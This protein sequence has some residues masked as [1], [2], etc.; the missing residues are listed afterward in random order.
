MN[1][2]RADVEQR[3]HDSDDIVTVQRQSFGHCLIVASRGA[4][5]QDALWDRLEE[6]GVRRRRDRADVLAPTRGHD[7]ATRRPLD[8]A[9]LEQKRLVDVLDG[10]L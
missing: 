5:P 3:S 8:E 2:T 9:E 1:D 6:R 4:P 10:V 7:P